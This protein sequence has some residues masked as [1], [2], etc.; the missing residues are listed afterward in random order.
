MHT[1]PQCRRSTISSTYFLHFKVPF[2]WQFIL[3]PERKRVDF[4][5][6]YK[7]QNIL[8]TRVGNLC[9]ESELRS[10]SCGD[11]LQPVLKSMKI[12]FT[13]Q[14]REYIHE[15][16]LESFWRK[17][18]P[19]YRKL[20]FVTGAKKSDTI[21]LYCFILTVRDNIP[22][23]NF[24]ILYLP[25]HSVVFMSNLLNA[26]DQIIWKLNSSFLWYVLLRSSLFLLHHHFARL[27]S[28]TIK[29]Y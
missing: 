24:F 7:K 11:L 12:L 3:I 13:T 10:K 29:T 20:S 17:W 1:L 25:L 15:C 2:T 16:L 21:N 4:N 19:N 23:E 26:I 5:S 8:Q 27:N 28:Y 6:R 22:D 14:Q 18:T 9:G